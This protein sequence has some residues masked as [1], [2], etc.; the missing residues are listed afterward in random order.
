MVKYAARG[1]RFLFQIGAFCQPFLAESA[2]KCG[3][4]SSSK[5]GHFWLLRASEE[6]RRCDHSEQK[7]DALARRHRGE[8][9]VAATVAAA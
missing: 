5:N 7:A 8:R 1:P 9:A 6:L 4:L 3:F 2:E